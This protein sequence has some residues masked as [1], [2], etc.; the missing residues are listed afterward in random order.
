MRFFDYIFYRT[1]FLYKYKWKDDTPIPYALSLVTIL[2]VFNIGSLFL[3]YAFF[4]KIKHVK[5]I[6]AAILFVGL[7]VFNVINYRS[8]NCF[9]QLSE[10]WDNEK[11]DLRLKKGILIIAYILISAVIFFWIALTLGKI[12]RG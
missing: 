4:N 11:K 10:R 5:P 12:N 7:L 8:K 3:I 6:Y 9:V 1:Y 2:Q